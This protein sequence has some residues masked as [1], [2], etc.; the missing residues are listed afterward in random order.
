[1]QHEDDDG[2]R[3]SIR[4]EARGRALDSLLVEHL[5]ALEGY[6]HLRLGA[7]LRSRESVSDLVQSVCADVLR[8]APNFVYRGDAQFRA[9]L[10][11]HAI[12]KIASKAEYH[13]RQRRSPEREVR[14]AHA[15]DEPGARVSQLFASVCSPSRGL[16]AR[17]FVAL[18]ESAFAKLPDDQ[19]EA[20]SLRRIVGLEYADIARRMERSEGAVRNLVHRGLARLSDLLQTRGKGDFA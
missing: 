12:H 9:W 13:G 6:V 20:V 3:D 1:M 5:A 10:F 14:I 4:S 19:Q 18:F 8:A 7:R 17:E 11:Q 15:D 16:A 2:D